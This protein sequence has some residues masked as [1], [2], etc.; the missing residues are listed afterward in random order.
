MA[1]HFLKKEQK[2]SNDKYK[3]RSFHKRD[4]PNCSHTMVTAP[5]VKFCSSEVKTHKLKQYSLDID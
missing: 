2:F 5:E 3:F 1:Q 4:F